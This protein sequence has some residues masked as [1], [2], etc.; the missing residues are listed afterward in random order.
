MMTG[1]LHMLAHRQCRYES[2][3]C[4]PEYSRHTQLCCTK[5]IVSGVSCKVCDNPMY[6][7]LNVM[8]V[9]FYLYKRKFRNDGSACKNLVTCF[10]PA[11]KSFGVC[12]QNLSLVNIVISL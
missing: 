1:M 10:D 4:S 6:C 9:I 5:C 2:S 12:L 8:Y 7:V 3:L 11:L